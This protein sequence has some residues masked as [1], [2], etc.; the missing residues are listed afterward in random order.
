MGTVN[1]LNAYRTI[2]L[3]ATVISLESCILVPFPRPA[4]DVEVFIQQEKI[5]EIEIGK[6]DSRE[7]QRV[8][9]EPDWSFD[10]GSR[11]VY[12]TRILSPGQ[13]GWCVISGVPTGGGGSCD[14]RSYE[15]ELLDIAFDSQG[16]VIQ[17]DVFIADFSECAATGVC[18][19]DHGGM[20]IYASAD[21]SQKAKEIGVESGWCVVFLYSWKPARPHTSVRFQVNG[22]EYPYWYLKD[23]DFFRVDLVEGPH[24]IG[25]SVNWLK[26][27]RPDLLSLNCESRSAYYIRILIDGSEGASFGLVPEDEGHR[28]I[29]GRNLVLPRDAS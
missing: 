25:A 6:T 27:V 20:K 19:Y 17:R 13:M 2:V 18:P 8:L 10:T 1:R 28:E 14:T 21:Y 24:T 12:K 7:L 29:L 3:V 11:V 22:N 9:G 26:G 4:K 16:T 15:T 23:T 5:D